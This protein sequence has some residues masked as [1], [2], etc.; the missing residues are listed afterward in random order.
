MLRAHLRIHLAKEDALLYPIL[1]AH[2]T[3]A[4]QGPIVGGMA[5]GIPPER[6][7]A[8]ID[9]FYPI[10]DPIDR[11][12]MADVWHQLM[13]EPVFATLSPLIEQASGD[14]WARITR[15]IGIA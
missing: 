14:D 7:P 6:M 10:V 3:P 1:R 8:M 12:K 9:W 5:G 11:V 2:A 13:P 4:E 15:E